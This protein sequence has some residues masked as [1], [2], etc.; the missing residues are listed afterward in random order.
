MAVSFL[1]TLPCY[2]F[3]GMY[4]DSFDVKVARKVAKICQQKHHTI[5]VGKEFLSNFYSL[6]EK[7]VYITDGYLDAPSG[8]IELYVNSLARELAKIRITGNYGSEVL[9]SIRAFRPKPPEKN[10][11]DL[12]FYKYICL[13]NKIFHNSTKGHKLSFAIF[14]QAPWYNF[15]RL[16]LEQSQLTIRTPFMDNE[17]LSV[18]YKAPDEAIIN[19]NI[20]LRLV[21]DGK[22]ELSKIITNRGVGENSY[23][24]LSKSIQMYYEVLKYA[25]IGYDYGM[26]Q[27][28]AQIDH[29][30]APL[31]IEKIFLGRHNFHHFRIWFKNE[32]ANCI[33]EILLDKLTLER[34][35]LN[36]KYI[37]KMVIGHVEGHRNYTKE[38][39]SL[40]SLEL[41][42]RNLF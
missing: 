8:A 11:F 25:E 17:L 12:E 10:I 39:G 6:A 37:E 41:I 42:Q 20:S 14:K 34:P 31:R 1:K 15:N 33:K 30:M 26:P 23:H 27:W 2:T 38:I 5:K 36:K 32:L 35:Y 9:R 16:S 22:I 21:K 19:D 13:A 18:V 29:L 4:C 40:I 7:A 3:G 24:I 28:L